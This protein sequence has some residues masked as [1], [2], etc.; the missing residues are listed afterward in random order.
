[1][2]P[3][4]DISRLIEIMAAL[5]DK[6]TGCPWDVEQ[7]FSTIAPYTL[8]ETYEVLEAIERNDLVNLEE[9]LGDLLLQV[10]F[11]AQMADELGAFDF[12]DVVN[13]ITKKLIRRHPHVF[14]DEEAK[15]SGMVKG[16][17][18]RIKA[19]EKAEKA[20][21]RDEKG[22]PPE[23]DK[24]SL[25]ADIPLEMPALQRAQKIQDKVAKVGF[26]W[27]DPLLVLDKVEE[28]IAE[29]RQAIEGGQ[30]NEIKD[31]IGDLLFTV[32]NLARQLDQDSEAAL[33]GCNE[34]FRRRFSHIETSVAANGE[35]LKGA[36]L[37]KMEAL[38]Q[39]AKKLEK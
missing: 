6:D 13:G 27:D 37:E 29:V 33:R 36:P 28:E 4:R 35:S 18:E 8:E 38:W 15:A 14:G 1:M 39:E 19:E 20:A 25:L 11:H 17:W 7:D 24:S 26:D 22:L 16:I 10:A 9:E 30:A 31:E 23:A 2:E 34:K 12:G 32:V 5:R 3:S 21:L